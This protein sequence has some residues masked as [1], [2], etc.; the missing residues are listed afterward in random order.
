MTT[1]LTYMLLHSSFLLNFT[2]VAKQTEREKSI[3]SKKIRFRR[4]QKSLT[5]SEN[6]R[7]A[8]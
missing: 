7:S 3:R 1:L 4:R 6:T 2:F 5:K 8:K